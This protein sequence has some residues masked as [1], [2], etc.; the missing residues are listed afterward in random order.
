MN[1]NKEILNELLTNSNKINEISLE[2]LEN[3]ADE[4]PYFIGI[5]KLINT[6]KRLIQERKGEVTFDKRLKKINSKYT[7]DRF[8]KADDED[9]EFTELEMQETELPF[10]NIENRNNNISE[11][12]VEKAATIDTVLS[13]EQIEE[14][15]NLAGDSNNYFNDDLSLLPHLNKHN[16]DK[17]DNL[18][19]KTY[20]QLTNIVERNGSEILERV[21]SLYKENIKAIA[22]EAK[23]LFQNKYQKLLLEQLGFSNYN[24]DNNLKHIVG[25]GDLLEDKLH[26]NGIFSFEQLSKLNEKFTE[27]LTVVIDYFPGRIERDNWQ[28]QAEKL[29]KAQNEPTRQQKPVETI[30]HL[31]EKLK[32]RKSNL[33]NFANEAET[34][35]SIE[36]ELTKNF[37]DWLVEIDEKKKFVEV[38]KNKEEPNEITN[39]VAEIE[40]EQPRLVKV[41]EDNLNEI[42]T[43]LGNKATDYKVTKPV[44]E[45]LPGF[46]VKE[47]AAKSLEEDKSIV[48]ITLAKIYEQQAYFDKAINIYKKLILKYPEKSSFFAGLIKDLEE[49]I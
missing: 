5:Q 32:T 46:S 18:D 4:F 35:E 40:E 39:E 45:F 28:Q 23:N 25:I 8:D 27:I 38:L 12:F 36:P 14:L 7:N 42:H 2:S 21:F 20:L 44:F 13:E 22:E 49:K 48:S 30:E 41:D 15:Q 17:L 26:K 37:L 9:E 11:H 1:I 24:S 29:Y 19:I 16:I 43:F 34:I 10:N 31:T 47:V 3:L 6:K 33:F